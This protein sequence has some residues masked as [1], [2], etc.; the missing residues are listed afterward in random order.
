MTDRISRS[1]LDNAFKSH[2]E[3][4]TRHD[5]IPP[6][7]EV[8]MSTGSRNAG[9]SFSL[10]CVGTDRS[11]DGWSGHRRPPVGDDFL[12]MTTREAYVEL[13]A[14]TRIIGDTIHALGD[15][16]ESDIRP[17]VD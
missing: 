2:V 6:G 5:L 9:V 7:L 17:A 1:D 11:V 4:L 8:Q 13:T 14:R 16:V 12:G 15:R 10:Y 3:T